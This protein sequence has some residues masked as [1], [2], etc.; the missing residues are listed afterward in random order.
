[1]ICAPQLYISSTF[2]NSRNVVV[3]VTLSAADP[4]S[5][6]VNGVLI[7]NLPVSSSGNLQ[8]SCSGI[9]SHGST[10]LY[11]DENG[12]VNIVW[13]QPSY[14]TSNFY[15]T[16][17]ISGLNNVIFPSSR[18]ISASFM[19]AT[20]IL[21]FSLG[22]MHIFGGRL[23]NAAI[24]FSSNVSAGACNVSVLFQP[25]NSSLSIDILKLGNVSFSYTLNS[26][27]LGFLCW[28]RTNVFAPWLRLA[29]TVFITID[30]SADF[31]ASFQFSPALH[32]NSPAAVFRCE[33]PGIVNGDAAPRHSFAT[34]AT[35]KNAHINS[36]EPVDVVYG[37][38]FPAVSDPQLLS[39][40]S[41]DRSD[42]LECSPGG[43]LQ[44]SN[45]T[46]ARW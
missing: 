18:V 35:F 28:Q 34:I 44:Y 16:C 36:V 46:Y 22:E 8:A 40:L 27:P 1:M 42:Y 11:N 43:Y 25:S 24:S 33:F 17:Q 38:S 9:A 6:P 14:L 20:K 23:S 26:N 31:Q 15:V 37:V 45:E 5:G 21:E 32:Y 10:A 3:A 39:S 12:Q 4:P 2:T 19:F 41:N 30:S 29:S 13:S 7:S